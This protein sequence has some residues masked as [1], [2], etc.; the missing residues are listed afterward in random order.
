M[1]IQMHPSY[2]SESRAVQ[3]DRLVE[4]LNRGWDMIDEQKALGQDVR[5]LEHAWVT[6]LHEYEMLAADLPQAA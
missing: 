2:R 4:R 5:K 6:L 3:L 1:K